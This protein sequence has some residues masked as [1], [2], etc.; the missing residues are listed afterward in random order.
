MSVCRKTAYKEDQC[1]CSL[2]MLGSNLPFAILLD[3][4]WTAMILPAEAGSE[5]E[6]K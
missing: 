4:I 6:L 1:F 3:A 5:K 2:P